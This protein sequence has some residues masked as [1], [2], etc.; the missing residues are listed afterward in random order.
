MMTTILFYCI[1]VI[2][3]SGT[4]V[5][6]W[7]ADERCHALGKY[8]QLEGGYLEEGPLDERDL[9]I[10]STLGTHRQLEGG[11]SGERPHD[12]SDKAVVSMVDTNLQPR[13][14]SSKT[15]LRGYDRRNLGL[16]TFQMKL[17]WEQEYCWQA[18]WFEREWCMSCYGGGCSEEEIIWIQECNDAIIQRFVWEPVEIPGRTK[19]GKLKPYTR[20]DLC[21]ENA[22]SEGNFGYFEQE[23]PYWWHF[24]LRPCDP[25]NVSTQI[26]DGYDV[27]NAHRL[28]ARDDSQERPERCMTMPHHPRA[29]EMMI[30]EYCGKKKF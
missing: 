19:T 3:L 27:D 28:V 13:L 6:A 26:L 16:F 8:R 23:Q 7:D 2:A 29:G 30:G 5:N 9:A 21:L 20:Q 18:E 14:D 15:N 17:H 11:H 1:V 10:V 24:L 25:D 12:E 22:G 4:F